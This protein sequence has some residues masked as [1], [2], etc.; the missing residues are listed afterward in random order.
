M[1][2]LAEQIRE[3]EQSRLQRACA[4]VEL[5]GILK[6]QWGKASKGAEGASN[7]ANPE[8]S[9]ATQGHTAQATG[10]AE[11]RENNLSQA[12]GM[13]NRAGRFVKRK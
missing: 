5:P 9:G 8:R 10:L 2:E 13:K 12:R 7:K 11:V 3:K 4:K 1:K 6:E